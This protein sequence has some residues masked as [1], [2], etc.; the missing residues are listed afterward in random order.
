MALNSQTVETFRNRAGVGLLAGWLFVSCASGQ[1]GFRSPVFEDLSR[2]G[3]V[4]DAVTGDIDGDG[5]D[6][7]VIALAHPEDPDVIPGRILV[8]YNRGPLAHPAQ[9]FDVRFNSFVTDGITQRPRGLALTD[10]NGDGL[11][12]VVVVSGGVPDDGE[13]DPLSILVNSG[14]HELGYVPADVV[15]VAV[16]NEPIDVAAADFDVDGDIDL[17]VLLQA[18][19]SVVWLTNPGAGR[20]TVPTLDDDPVELP[21]LSDPTSIEPGDLDSAEEPDV[22]VIGSSSEVQVIRRPRIGE[23]EV[24]GV[25]V[26]G[27]PGGVAT[28][29]VVSGGS[30]DELHGPRIVRE[31]GDLDE[32]LVT[33]R[34]AGEIAVIGF[35]EALGEFIA[36]FV[37][38]DPFGVEV[39]PGAV[40]AGDF[41]EDG[42]VDFAHQARVVSGSDASADGLL[43]DGE[44][45]IIRVRLN[46]SVPGG[47]PSFDLPIDAFPET[48]P[49][50]LLLGDLNA[51]GRPDFV[52]IDSDEVDLSGPPEVTSL[53]L[54]PSPD[55]PDCDA[56]LNFDG[57][58]TIEDLLLVLRFF[59]RESVAGDI[60]GDG[61]TDLQDLQAV[62]E[63]FGAICGGGD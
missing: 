44:G 18:D 34:E 48:E 14:S 19:G 20:T 26:G 63:L 1:F 50:I 60:T 17:A 32:I 29:S 42:L 6:D 22:V 3:I 38:A 15:S 8:L 35:D 55:D 43:E 36:E 9:I 62:I 47:G 13:P 12:D 61:V 40:V 11:L 10:Y 33:V 41:N 49:T 54:N 16:G 37:S 4:T 2:V 56:D 58:V 51:D 59:G 57:V 27:T 45:S 31:E 46:T 30:P 52:S 24:T 28:A 21:G 5:Y 53:V 7:V 23:P 39:L 25:E